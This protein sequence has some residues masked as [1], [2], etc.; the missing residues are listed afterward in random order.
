MSAPR[1][2]VVW[3]DSEAYGVR[4]AVERTGEKSLRAERWVEAHA[5][6]LYR[7]AL[8]RVRQ[9]SVAEDLVQET[10][11]AAWNSPA[12]RQE[13]DERAER[14]WLFGILRHKVADHFRKQARE[15][16]PYDPATLADLE[17]SQFEGGGW[18]GTHWSSVTGPGV[19]SQ[20]EASLHQ[21]EFLKALEACTRQLPE[22]VGQAF[23]LREL[24]GHGVREIC[25]T[26]GV[27]QN[28]L[29]VMLHRARLAL[30]RCLELKWF[31]RKERENH[32]T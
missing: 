30:R 3:G 28:N 11:L 14:S 17:A 16:T 12:E 23:L 27:S 15:A 6:V 32:P 9:P 13:R 1:L 24:D 29:F 21:Q 20:P 10:L 25:S 4:I 31:G 8:L 19:W 22:K 2:A 26:L 5:D 18:P 7:H